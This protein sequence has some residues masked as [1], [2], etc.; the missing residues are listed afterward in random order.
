MLVLTRDVGIPAAT[1]LRCFGK[2]FLQR[3]LKLLE[4]RQGARQPGE[5]SNAA[6]QSLSLGKSRLN[7]HW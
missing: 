3:V 4:R 7:R 5:P 1:L 2:L 6:W